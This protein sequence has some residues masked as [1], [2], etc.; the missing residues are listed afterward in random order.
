MLVRLAGIKAYILPAPSEILLEIW[1]RQGRYLVAA[2]FTLRPMLLGFAMAVIGGVAL[3]VLV[4]F[5]RT[6]EQTIYPLLIFFQIVPKIAVAPLFIIWFVR[7]FPKVLLVFP[8][9]FPW[10]CHTTLPLDRPRHHGSRAYHRCRRL[11]TFW[12]VQ[13]PHARRRCSRASRLQLRL[14]HRRVSRSWLDRASATCCSK[15]RQSQYHH[16]IWRSSCSL[17][18]ASRFM[19]RSS[20]SSG[21]LS[22]GVSQRSGGYA[23][24]GLRTTAGNDEKNSSPPPRFCS[25]PRPGGG[26]SDAAAQLA[27]HGFHA[28]PPRSRRLLQGRRHRFVI[29][30]ARGRRGAGH[31]RQG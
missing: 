9:F 4:A 10:W 18:L 24:P 19:R 2:D 12:K 15:L 27:D 31:R 6:M 5:S 29:G 20:S 3:A 16:G 11:R 8:S 28:V 13:I 7:L 1:N 21:S 14:G 25:A 23:A 30:E 26:Q 17:R 22:L